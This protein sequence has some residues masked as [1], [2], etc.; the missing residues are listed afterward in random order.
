[1]EGAAGEGRPI[2]IS[3][4]AAHL[5]PVWHFWSSGIIPLKEEVH[6][7]IDCENHFFF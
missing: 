6:N 5:W 2:L 3:K 7:L 4:I 1:M